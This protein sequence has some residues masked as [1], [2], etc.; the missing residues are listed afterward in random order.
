MNLDMFCDYNYFQ[1]RHK[2]LRY[3]FFKKSIGWVEDRVNCCEAR[4][5]FMHPV[6]GMDENNMQISLKD[7]DV[8]HGEGE[9]NDI[10][11]KSNGTQETILRTNKEISFTVFIFIAFPFVIK[12]FI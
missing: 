10:L 9:E 12:L 2:S 4:R 1:I 7:Q 3:H 8:H 11:S 5:Y 6:K